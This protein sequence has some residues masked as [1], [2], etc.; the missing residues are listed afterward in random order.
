MKVLLRTTVAIGAGLATVL[1]A[2]LAI[3]NAAWWLTGHMATFDDPLANAIKFGVAAAG[4][5]A[6]ALSIGVP[7]ARRR[8]LL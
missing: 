3:E 4:G 2:Q 8:R 6:L 7:P 5:F 1:A